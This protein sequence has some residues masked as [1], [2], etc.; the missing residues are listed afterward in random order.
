MHYEIGRFIKLRHGTTLSCFGTRHFT[1]HAATVDAQKTANRENKIFR[2][3]QVEGN[4][5]TVLE[6]EVR[7]NV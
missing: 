4:K 2:V 1:K 3:I 7:P 5:R 6:D